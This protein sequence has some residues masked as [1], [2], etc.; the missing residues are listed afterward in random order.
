MSSG[1]GSVR[2][3]CCPV[4]DSQ[5]LAAKGWRRVVIGYGI[6]IDSLLFFVQARTSRLEFSSEGTKEYE[7]SLYEC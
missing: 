4:P 2:N 5:R 7:R 1:S 3:D 6:A